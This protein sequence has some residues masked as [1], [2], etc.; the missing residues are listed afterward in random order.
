MD[1]KTRDT[2]HGHA[3]EEF[4]DL[5]MRN[6]MLLVSNTFNVNVDVLLTTIRLLLIILRCKKV[7]P[8]MHAPEKMLYL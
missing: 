7:Q 8:C 6:R 5:I 3:S 1:K 4:T 2:Y